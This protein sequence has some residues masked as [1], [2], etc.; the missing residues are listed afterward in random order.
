MSLISFS[1]PSDTEILKNL[2]EQN[3]FIDFVGEGSVLQ[4]LNETIYIRTVKIKFNK[5]E[6]LRNV[7]YVKK[8]ISWIF[9][10]IESASSA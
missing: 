7:I 3:Q 4:N 5:K 1:K 9:K 10:S 6:I 2:P 8:G